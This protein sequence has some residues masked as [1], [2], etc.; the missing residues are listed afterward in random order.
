MTTC[1]TMWGVII[2]LKFGGLVG[3]G[4]LLL[5]LAILAF[6][7][8]V[9][10]MNCLC[11]SAVATNG[12]HSG[13]YSL[14]VANLGPAWGATT[15]L[16]Y[17]MGMTSLATVEI[18]GAVEAF[19]LLMRQAR[20]EGDLTG[21]QYTNTGLLGSLGLVGLGWLRG[22][23]SHT[24]HVIGMVVLV[25]FFITVLAVTAGTLREAS[26]E[27]LSANLYPPDGWAT[28]TG[29][30]PST[31]AKS[32]PLASAPARPLCLLSA[33]LAALGSSVLPERGPATRRPA[34]A[35]GARAS[36]L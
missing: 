4:G 25:A 26:L 27:N 19:D 20:G 14:L 21:S 7:A 13:A 22:V 9:Q 2:F 33:R 30:T 32:G 16:L 15:S 11:V 24:V 3:E 1:E 31:M 35:S 10:F 34:T 17:Y 23:N 8:C 6:A 5:S 28:L 12:L 29:P 36:R 18:C